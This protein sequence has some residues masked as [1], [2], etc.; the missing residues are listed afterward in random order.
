MAYL[1]DADVFIRAKNL[2]YGLVFCP[3]FWEWLVIENSAGR[4]CSI[5]KVGDGLPMSDAHHRGHCVPINPLASGVIR[6]LLQ[7]RCKLR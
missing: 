6:Q 3:A 4:V 7:L 5:E 1:L 2:H